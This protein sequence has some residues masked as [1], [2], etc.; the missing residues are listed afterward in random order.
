MSDD[1]L[2]RLKGDLAV[3]RGAMGLHLP[4]DRGILVAGISLAATATAAA[5]LSLLVERDS[6]QQA[7]PGCIMVAGLMGLYLRS[8]RLPDLDSRVVAQVAVSISI[9]GVVWVAACGYLIAGVAGPLLEPSRTAAL[10]AS[11]VVLLLVFSLFLFRSALASRQQ[12]YCLGL[13][14]STLL[15]G[16]LLPVVDWRFSEALAHVS[17]AVGYL[18]AAAIQSA[19]LRE[20]AASHASD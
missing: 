15:A 10:H 7:L 19:Q 5:V 20:A 1:E 16:M 18:A 17:M 6:L 11:S 12:H 4:F 3:I 9:Y 13:A 14:A 2:G 8:R